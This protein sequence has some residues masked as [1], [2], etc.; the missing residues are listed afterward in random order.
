M[1]RKS[2]A[3]LSLLLA[4]SAAASA[5]TVE[6]P[7]TITV[8]GEALIM[9]VPDE[10][11]IGVGV[12]TFNASLQKGLELNTAASKRVLDA[13]KKLGVEDAFIKTDDLSVDVQYV[14]G[15]HPAR[16][17]EGYTLRRMY[18]V[19]LKDVHKAS[20]LVNAALLNGANIVTG[21]DYRTTELRKHRDAARAAAIK[22][23]QE[24]A[25]ALLAVLKCGV[26]KP[27]TVSEASVGYYGYGYNSYGN[28]QTQNAMSYAEG[29][30][31]SGD[32]DVDTV[33]AGQIGVRATVEIVFDITTG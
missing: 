18:T 7:R 23:A 5:Q 28:A 1:T 11:V 17:I 12:E 16:G 26:G 14:D 19:T 33:P 30:G 31:S 32:L 13:V 4:C 10:A 27:R 8:T 2:F 21:I 29:G 9:V 24:K 15:N 25:T 22:A 3:V 6:Y 20:E